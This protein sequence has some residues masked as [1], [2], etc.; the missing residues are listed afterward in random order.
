M[1]LF[2]KY[3]YLC[4]TNQNN[5]Q[6][7]KII[8]TPIKF[9]LVMKKIV[10]FILLVSSFY[11][12]AQV[13]V[14]T[15]L[16]AA[17]LDV[18]ATNPSGTA[19]NVDGI[20]IPRISRQR[21]QLM[22]A[23]PTSTL[24]YINDV[25]SGTASG[26]TVNVTTVGF[27][28]FNGTIWE[29]IAAGL[30]TDWSLI[31]NS[32]TSSATNFLGTTDNVDLIFR[33]NN[34]RAGRLGTDNTSL[35][36]NSLNPATTGTRNTAIGANVLNANTTGTRNTAIGENTLF[37]NTTGGENVAMG[38][39]TLYSNTIGNQNTAIGRNSLTTNT[40]GSSNTGL[41]YLTLRDNTTGDFNTAVGRS[42]LISNT[43][44]VE[45]VSVGVN[46][47]FAN[48][49]GNYNS[50]F[51]VQSSRLNTTGSNNTAIGY[52]S[53]YS[54]ITG[55]NNVAIGNQAGYNETG[56]NRLYIENSNANAD[57][58]LIYGEFT[59]GAKVLR[60][61]SQFQIGNP[62]VT[63]YSFPTTRP[64]TVAGQILQYNAL[65][66]LSF[67]SP[68]AALNGFAWLTTG[69]SGTTPG[70]NFIG[71][72]DNVDLRIR[73]NNNDRFNFT[74]NGRLRSYDD[75]TAGQPTYSWNPGTGSTMGM[76]RI[77]ANIL[78]FSTTST[79]RLRVN[80]T[81]QVIV[82]STTAFGVSTF[83]SLATGNNDAIDGSAAGTGSAVYGQNTGT[84]E[85]VYGLTTNANGIGVVGDNTSTGT[86]VYGQTAGAVGAGVFGVANVANGT[87]SYGTSNGAGGTGV[88]GNTS[89]N[90]GNGVYGQA[91]GTNGT[92][93]YGF[94]NNAGG[95]GVIGEATQGGR[96]GVRG[97]NNNATGIGVFGSTTG[98]NAYGVRGQSATTATGV[99]GT[100][101]GTGNGVWG[102]NSGTGVG[103]R[104]QST[105]TGIGV[106]GFNNGAG[107][108][109]LGNNTGTGRGVEG[110]S[111]ST[112]IGVFGL[113]S[114]TGVGVQGQSVSSGIGVIGFNTDTGVG[115]Q[116]QNSGSGSAVVGINTS[117]VGDG[118]VGQ[119]PAGSAGF[120]VF[121]NGD[122]GA[123]GVKPFYI[124]HPT[125][126]ATKYLRHF[127]LE[128]NEVLNVYRGNVILDANGEATVTLPN[129]FDKININFSYNLTS[130]GAKSD[131]FIKEEI[132]NNQFKIAGGLP[133]QKISW[134]VYSERND[135]YL[136]QFP[137]KRE[138]EINKNSN[139]AGNY[140]MPEL[141]NQPKEK[142][143]Y[144][145]NN[146]QPAQSKTVKQQV[147]E[148]RL[149]ESKEKNNRQSKSEPQLSDKEKKIENE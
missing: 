103:V 115:V 89:G 57:N 72:T 61:N 92:G 3:L 49:I 122:M 30:S 66:A 64:A 140:L 44:G 129:Y 63:G 42:S 5:L 16:P 24:V 105:T 1:F 143:I 113:N 33:R 10:V 45:N 35:G 67:Q 2:H 56:S 38:A 80:A 78:G 102:E 7:K 135:A 149:E 109:V 90:L 137:E 127:A 87:G 79:E 104:G 51:G 37:S 96:Y 117:L 54:N 6:A 147:E 138:V 124:D 58:A 97:L 11:L 125:E 55:N 73:T 62:T 101:N 32:G 128:S 134:Q 76:Y 31:G 139:D 14:G 112:G 133:N 95:D 110:Q 132:I 93:V 47:L 131:V 74:S 52:Q 20:L 119:T 43:I 23:T 77:G 145:Q 111:A 18:T 26:T 4:F 116:G 21:A 34:L 46:S 146:L 83:Y 85:G 41:G 82:N 60:T 25:A 141:Y 114:G 50:G 100:N 118:I 48:T 28:F 148:N 19:T 81:G 69:N 94:A 98:A 126:P 36:L 106:F 53:L 107:N 123:S 71:T 91:T 12:N 29:K 120:A 65:G 9:I 39:G 142:G 22:A 59:T 108:G 144:N 99:V 136:Q 86:G 75:G 88:W 121:A 13:G 8:L 27:Y 17:T 40:T 130:I 70:T 68:G 15:T 84:G